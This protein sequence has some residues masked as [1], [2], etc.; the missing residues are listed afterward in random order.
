[1]SNVNGFDRLGSLFGVIAMMTGLPLPATMDHIGARLG[2]FI[3]SPYAEAET[4]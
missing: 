2:Q 4:G 1:L 3:R